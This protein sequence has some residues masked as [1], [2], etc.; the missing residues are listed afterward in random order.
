MFFQDHLPLVLTP[1]L[2]TLDEC[3]VCEIQNGSKRFFLTVLYRYPSQSIE[4]FSLFKQKW[5]EITINTNDCSPTI[6]MR[7]GEFNARNS[8]WWNGDS[9]N[10]QGTELAEP[11]AE[12]SL[13]QVTDEPSHIAPNYASCVDSM[14][15]TET[16][17]VTNSGVLP[18]LFSRC[19]HPLIFSKL[20]FTILFPPTYR[21]RIWD[22]T[23][24]NVNAIRQAV[25]GVDWNRAFNGLNLDERVNFSTEY[26]LNIF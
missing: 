2:T 16:N 11:A 20:S 12:Y 14:F 23:T 9:T 10:L 3:F 26:V 1:N 18:P 8:E 5:E 6:S 15:I 19:H 13:N 21:R 22:F 4:P 25:N 24:A 7:I 17:F